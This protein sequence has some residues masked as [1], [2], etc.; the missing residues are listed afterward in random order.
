MHVDAETRLGNHF[1]ETCHF[2][3]M[4]LAYSTIPLIYRKIRYVCEICTVPPYL[5][6]TS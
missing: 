3:K 4:A 5:V 2:L 6:K 1:E